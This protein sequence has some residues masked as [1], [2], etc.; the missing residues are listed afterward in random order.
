MM[1]SQFWFIYSFFYFFSFILGWLEDFM[2][3][4]NKIK[5]LGLCQRG[6]LNWGDAQPLAPKR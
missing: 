3:N 4:M 5:P 2:S 6:G 1:I